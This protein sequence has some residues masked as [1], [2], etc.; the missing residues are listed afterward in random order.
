MTT[1]DTNRIIIATGILAG[2]SSVFLVNNII[3]A[4]LGPAA[5]QDNYKKNIFIY[6]EFDKTYFA[7]LYAGQEVLRL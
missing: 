3:T 1:N 6:N 7:M 2:F 4:S 5:F